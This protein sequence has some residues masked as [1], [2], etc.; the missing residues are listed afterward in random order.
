VAPPRL[1]QSRVE[2][3]SQGLEVVNCLSVG[4]TNMGCYVS[5]EGTKATLRD[6][7]PRAEATDA[8][9]AIAELGMLAAPP[10]ATG[11]SRQFA[12]GSMARPVV[13]CF[14]GDR[15]TGVGVALLRPFGRREAQN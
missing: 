3:P 4:M 13:V 6:A 8:T 1:E 5:V 11:R 15:R 9:T 12:F 14:T 2:A 7:S 10:P